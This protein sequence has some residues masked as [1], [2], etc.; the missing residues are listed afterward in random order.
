VPWQSPQFTEIDMNAEIGA[1]QRDPGG[2]DHDPAHGPVPLPA[3]AHTTASPKDA[4]Q[5]ASSKR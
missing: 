4:E 3:E 5:D 2:A 1:Y